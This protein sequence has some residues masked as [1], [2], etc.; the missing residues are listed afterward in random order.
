MKAKFNDAM[1]EQMIAC[2]EDLKKQIEV[3]P[4]DT[5]VVHSPDVDYTEPMTLE[6]ITV[7]CTDKTIVGYVVV[8]Y[9]VH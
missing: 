8:N 5:Q 9:V 6:P 7:S 2:L 4:Q 3:L 1:R